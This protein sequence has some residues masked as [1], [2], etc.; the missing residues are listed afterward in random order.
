MQRKFFNKENQNAFVQFW[1]ENIKKERKGQLMYIS[2]YL[3]Q[4]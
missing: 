4:C 1:E 2:Y 3:D